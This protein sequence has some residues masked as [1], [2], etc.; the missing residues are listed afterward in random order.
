MS[1]TQ[2]EQLLQVTSS[3]NPT[4]VVWISRS[5]LHEPQKL[6]ELLNVREYVVL[7][8]KDNNE[9]V[10]FN[11]GE[12]VPHSIKRIEVIDT[13]GKK[14]SRESSGEQYVP[15]LCLRA[16]LTP[17]LGYWSVLYALKLVCIGSSALTVLK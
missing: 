15:F 6:G 13:G 9:E 5:L 11:A 8:R 14:R 17:L 12:E 4:R 10:Y 1:T 7:V 2:Q 3:N 16:Q